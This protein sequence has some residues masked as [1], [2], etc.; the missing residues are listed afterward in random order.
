MMPTIPKDARAGAAVVVAMLAAMGGKH[1][2]LRSH[3]NGALNHGVSPEQL[4]QTLRMVAVYAGFPAALDA[5]P[6]MEEVFAARGIPRPARP[7]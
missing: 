2:P 6:I 1:G 7:A 5:W 3:F 4:A